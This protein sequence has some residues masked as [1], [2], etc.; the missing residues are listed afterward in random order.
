[1]KGY[2]VS[3]I[4][5]VAIMVFA[6]SLIMS[7][8]AL[9]GKQ[10]IESKVNI[11]EATVKELTKLPGIGKKKAEAI[12]AYRKENGKFNSV[13]ELKKIDGIGK[14]TFERIKDDI[15]AD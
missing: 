7:G 12:I 15:A 6:V 10:N 9:A 11:N 1:M 4:C 5:K 2:I 8:M 3:R 14:K 13:E